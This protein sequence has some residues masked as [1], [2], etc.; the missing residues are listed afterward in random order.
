M[1]S[2]ENNTQGE[3]LAASDNN[4]I[5][6][7]RKD[8]PQC[9]GN[10]TID[11]IACLNPPLSMK[12]GSLNMI[13]DAQ[14]DT[15][16]E[17]ATEVASTDVQMV[18]SNDE[19][20]E[21]EGGLQE[22]S[23][24]NRYFTNNNAK[25]LTNFE[26]EG[27][28]CTPGFIPPEGFAEMLASGQ[29]RPS[30]DWPDARNPGMF[31]PINS[32]LGAGMP[33]GYTEA[34]AARIVDFRDDIILPIVIGDLQ[35]LPPGAPRPVALQVSKTRTFDP[36]EYMEDYAV[37]I[38]PEEHHPELREQCR[39]LSLRRKELK[40]VKSN[41]HIAELG[42]PFGLQRRN[43]VTIFDPDAMILGPKSDPDPENELDNFICGDLQQNTSSESDIAIDGSQKN[44]YKYR[45]C[46]GCVPAAQ[47]SG[48]DTGSSSS[49]DQEK[50]EKEPAV[51][52]KA[53]EKVEK[54]RIKVQ[55][56]RDK[57]EKEREKVDKDR[58]RDKSKSN[59]DSRKSSKSS[60]KERHHHS[61]NH[62]P[63]LL[64]TGNYSQLPSDCGLKYRRFYH[65]ETHTNG[66]AQVLH[67][68][69]EEIKHL[70][71]ESQRELATEFFTVAFSE[72]ER[73]RALYVMA[74]VHGAAT[75][76]P[77]LLAYMADNYPYLTVKNGLLNRT[78][79]LETTNMATYN[80]HVSKH[81]D[82]GTVRYGPLHQISLVGTAHEEVGGYFPDLLDR[83]EE[84]SFLDMTMP[85]GALSLIHMK[86]QESNDGPIL[87]CR[88]G[89]QLVPTVDSKSPFKR[90][91]TGINELRN[92]Q[93][94]PRLSEAREHLFEDRT[95]AHAD[96]VG[97]GLDRRTTAAVGVL[98]AI[99]GGRSEGAINR[100]TK[101]VVAFA[102]Q[103]F[104][105]LSE[106]L[107][108]D[109]HEPPISQCVTWIEDA[110]LN[111]LRRDG[112]RYARINLYDNDI[113]FLPRNIIH[114]FRTVS[115]VT[116]VAWHV[117][118]RQYYKNEVEMHQAMSSSSST[119]NGEVLLPPETPT[120]YREKV[121]NS[122]EAETETE[123]ETS[124]VVP[125][126]TSPPTIAAKPPAKIASVSPVSPAHSL[127][128]KDKEKERDRK[129][130]RDRDRDRT[131]KHHSS[132][133]SHDHNR[134]HQQ[135]NHHHQS[136]RDKD[137]DKDKS[138]HH[139]SR[140]SS[141]SN[142]TSKSNS[143]NKHH[144][145][146]RDRDKSRN[147]SHNADKSKQSTST[148]SS[149][150]STNST[151]KQSSPQTNSTTNKQSSPH[152][153]KH[154]SNNKTPQ[155]SSTKRTLQ[156]DQQPKTETIEADDTGP[157]E[158]ISASPP[159]VNGSTVAADAAASVVRKLVPDATPPTKPPKV[160][161][162]S[163]ESPTKSTDI[164]GDILKGMDRK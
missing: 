17:L 46:N 51:A 86:R 116:S 131:H 13:A 88:P 161:R 6:P 133:S 52:E 59:S 160:R 156:I 25:A 48:E 7:R 61:H 123:T 103:D 43:Y 62:R 41:M 138:S 162:L 111:Q 75:Y 118:L 4:S 151:S 122:A 145:D 50:V 105:T 139:R 93:Y 81:Y 44:D 45:D 55:K 117:R 113:Y 159:S 49:K 67:M 110:K 92:L 115:A 127:V 84:N 121:L 108:L 112:I 65:V 71:R 21:S 22:E 149:K 38:D 102:A 40:I 12:N 35:G 27:W 147:R 89:E 29:P 53:Q 3:K 54:S 144:H 155:Q 58:E 82:S 33:D 114:Q 120:E 36:I 32:P 26:S 124:C 125:I 66:G 146:H 87:W 47:P 128:S 98:K 135:H 57:V 64:T 109:L 163:K 16:E 134:D 56:E 30:I 8:C 154:S 73:E 83:L 137:K 79:D 158:Q 126:P 94:L 2:D 157:V 34:I 39:M 100:I 90:R 24:S 107:Q 63:T 1:A 148:S 70:S 23:Q 80:A 96:H 68:Y 18:E 142:S 152:S 20:A 130:D 72:D 74:I 11:C 153:H 132:S 28:R 77:D 164:L 10:I 42:P 37:E 9:Q 141:S 15:E 95:K 140:H 143:T 78:S 76:L 14:V 99:H 85:W 5:K 106:K 91:R 31:V 60:T 19:T 150:S 101:D 119:T 104:D 97:H 136:S 69:N 129:S